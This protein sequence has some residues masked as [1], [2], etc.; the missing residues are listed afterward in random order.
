MSARKKNKKKPLGILSAI[1]EFIGVMAGISMVAGR[2]IGLHV[3]NLLQEKLRQPKQAA[4]KPVQVEPE[5]K[6]AAVENKTTQKRVKTKKKRTK[7]K[8][9]AKK[10]K[11]VK[12]T[13]KKKISKKP[14]VT[15]SK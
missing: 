11:T 7:K 15:R 14:T 4:R 9:S 6:I 3:K 10:K 1:P 8:K 13:K 5:K 2:W 12:K